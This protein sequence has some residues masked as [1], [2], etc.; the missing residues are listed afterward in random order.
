MKGV[1]EGREEIERRDRER[2]GREREN[3]PVTL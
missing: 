3:L 2:V 1:R